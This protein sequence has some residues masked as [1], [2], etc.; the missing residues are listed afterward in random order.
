MHRREV[1]DVET[2][3]ALARVRA[4]PY[5]R[6]SCKTDLGLRSRPLGRDRSHS[7]EGTAFFLPTSSPVANEKG[8]GKCGGECEFN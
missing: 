3:W 8:S 1:A 2:V 5:R 4:E 7:S 6:L